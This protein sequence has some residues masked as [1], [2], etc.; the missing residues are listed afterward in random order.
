MLQSYHFPTCSFCVKNRKIENATVN[1][2]IDIE[3]DD[4]FAVPA[5]SGS[6]FNG[7]RCEGQFTV[8]L[9]NTNGLT[10]LKKSLGANLT[11]RDQGDTTKLNIVLTE[12]LDSQSGLLAKLPGRPCMTMRHTWAF[13][14]IEKPL[15]DGMGLFPEAMKRC[16]M[17][18]FVFTRF[19]GW[20]NS[21][22]TSATVIAANR[23]QAK[24]LLDETLTHK[25]LAPLQEGEYSLVE[26]NSSQPGVVVSSD[27]SD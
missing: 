12:L 17:K 16:V 9:P 2:E 25:G 5:P 6:Y 14:C 13:L 22:Q 8:E 10:Y 15:C 24:E 1:I 7:M 23:H 11:L 18:V 19:P 27:G 4:P 26:L 3:D 20:W 21:T